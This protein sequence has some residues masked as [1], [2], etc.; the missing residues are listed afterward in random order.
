[1]LLAFFFLNHFFS[2]FF[3][4]KS[5]KPF[6]ERRKKKKQKK[7]K[8]ILRSLNS[9]LDISN[10]KESSTTTRFSQKT[11]FLISIFLFLFFLVSSFPST[12]AQIANPEDLNLNLASEPPPEKIVEYVFPNIGFQVHSWDSL[13]EW[14][15]G[16]RKGVRYFKIDL[17]FTSPLEC[18]FQP[19]S[20]DQRGC[21][22]RDFSFSHIFFHILIFFF[23][24][25]LF[26][27]IQQTAHDARSSSS[28]ETVQYSRSTHFTSFSS[29]DPSISPKPQ[30][31]HLDCTLLQRS[32]RSMRR[33]SRIRQLDLPCGRSSAKSR[34]HPNQTSTFRSFVCSGRSRNT[35]GNANLSCESVETTRSNLCFLSRSHSR[36]LFKLTGPRIRSVHLA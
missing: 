6:L 24:F 27:F 28:N 23:F 3:R 17:H 1:M 22:V 31:N 10:I 14:P 35:R 36:S 8:M 15:Q 12:L 7:K 26:R 11:T 20:N 5:L 16:F 9:D 30:P 18:S 2:P 29:F 25:S 34:N 4:E 21:L 13:D 19:N 32:R 33:I